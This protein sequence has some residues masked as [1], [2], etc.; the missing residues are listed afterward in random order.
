MFGNPLAAGFT[1]SFTIASPAVLST[2][3]TGT[4][5]PAVDHGR[6]VFN[7]P[8]NPSTFTFDQFALVDP[9]NNPVNVT[10]ITPVSGSN[11]TQFDVTFDSQGPAGTYH[12]TVG[13]NIRDMF[14][15][16]LATGFTSSFTIASPAVLSTT[17]TGTF[18]PAVDHGRL[19]FNEPMNPSTFTFDQFALVDPNSNPVNV[20]S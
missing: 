14:G 12:L 9:N 1:S 18:F 15:N 4:F 13:P 8:M 20:I 3:L 11:N 5:F 6:L 7:E 19:V 10:S 16:P 2:T 17:L